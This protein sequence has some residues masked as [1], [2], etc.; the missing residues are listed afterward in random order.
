[1]A[2]FGEDL[3]RE[4][5]L[6]DI[7]LEEIAEATNISKPFLEALEQNAFDLLPGG[8]Y[9]RGFIRS[10]AR[11][12]GISVDETL[13]SY[14]AEEARQ[15]NISAGL[16][17]AAAPAG[18]AG[19][20]RIVE[21]V[22]AVAL[23]V[24][25]GL[26]GLVYWSGTSNGSPTI[27]PDPEAHGAALRA[28]FKRSGALPSLPVPGEMDLGEPAR[29]S[30]GDAVPLSANDP[31]EPEIL[32]R[33][34]A[35]ETTRVLLTCAGAPKLDGELWVGAERHFFC[36]PPVRVTAGNGG[37]IEYSVG[38]SQL[39]VL[40]RPGERVQGRE[41]TATTPETE[42]RSRTKAGNGSIAP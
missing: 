15:K 2:S 32:V 42:A 20:S 36:R 28:R 10:Y 38:P 37:G 22:V 1:M 7:S 16:P 8:A 11:Y 30:A 40:G 34:R 18:S 3:K 23:V 4:R 29:A 14:K 21:T 41:I 26:I 25:T 6:R 5:E 9:T 17:P 27:A 35:R 33:L 24:T 19:G 31:G 13:D 39:R 12:I